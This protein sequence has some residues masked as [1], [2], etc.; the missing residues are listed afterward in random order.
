MRHGRA[1]DWADG[2]DAERP[3]TSEGRAE[4]EDVGRALL[5]LGLAPSHA[6]SSPLLRARQTLRCATEAA[7]MELVPCVMHP[8][9]PNAPPRATLAALAAELERIAASRV[10]LLAVGH[11]PNVTSTLGLLL[12]GAASHAF[13]FAPG[14]LAHV[15]VDQSGSALR[16]SLA[17]FYP[18]S[19]LVGLLRRPT[20]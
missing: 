18:A 7:G 9:V 8:L 15:Y 11:N 14:T 16:G 2:G 6:V 1:E 17:G 13:D 5:C 4:V 12:A 3:L 10:R 20:A 19:A